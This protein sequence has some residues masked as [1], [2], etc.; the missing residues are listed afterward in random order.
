[1]QEITTLVHFW[2]SGN[3]LPAIMGDKSS[4]QLKHSQ[5]KP[6][7]DLGKTKET[8]ESDKTNEMNLL[9]CWCFIGFMSSICVAPDFECSFAQSYQI[10]NLVQ[11]SEKPVKS[12]AS[13]CNLVTSESIH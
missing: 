6:H 2:R 7:R 4:A 8:M 10:C 9:H 13:E 12:D 11:T 1:M 3:E 5:L